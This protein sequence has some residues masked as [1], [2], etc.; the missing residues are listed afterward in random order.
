MGGKREIRMDLNWFALG[1]I[2]GTI[3]FRIIKSLD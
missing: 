3:W 2:S 1:G